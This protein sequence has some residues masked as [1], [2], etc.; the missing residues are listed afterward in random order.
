MLC[1]ILHTFRQLRQIYGIYD[2]YILE[3]VSYFILIKKNI[4]YMNVKNQFQINV[5]YLYYQIEKV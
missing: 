4:F 2:T 5:I 1:L 3:K